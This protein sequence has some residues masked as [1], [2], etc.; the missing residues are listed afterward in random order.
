MCEQSV[1]VPG[2]HETGRHFE[3]D[4]PDQTFL[5]KWQN[6]LLVWLFY[7]KSNLEKNCTKMGYLN[8]YLRPLVWKHLTYDGPDKNRNYSFGYSLS[9]LGN[10]SCWRVVKKVTQ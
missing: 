8:D 9:T 10:F 7:W 5:D 3:S 6:K 4:Y 2:E 1:S